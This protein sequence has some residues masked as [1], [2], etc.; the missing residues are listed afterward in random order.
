L[1]TFSNQK[2]GVRLEFDTKAAIYESNRLA[3]WYHAHNDAIAGRLRLAPGETLLDVG[4]GTGYLIRQALAMHPLASAIGVD[5][6]PEMVRAAT[7]AAAGTTDGR[8]QFYCADWEL[9][10]GAVMEALTRRRV[11]QA[12]CASTLHY[13]DDPVSALRR[14]REMLT[15]DGALYLLERRRERSVMT[16]AWDLAHRHVL[17]D[18]VRFYDTAALLGMIRD[19]GFAQA[20]IVE[21]I[22]KFF[23]NNKISTNLSII[24]AIK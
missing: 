4:C 22:R 21:T 1:S 20:E 2:S 15:R 5:L 11:S 23:W 7:D 19:A 8:A 3:G 9:P 16:Q 14:I 24:R 13:F 6:S 17:R 12:V 10:A 18:N